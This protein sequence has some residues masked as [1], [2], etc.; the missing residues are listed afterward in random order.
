MTTQMIS[1]R[2]RK[3]KK[4]STS[5]SLCQPKEWSRS[6]PTYPIAVIPDHTG[7]TKTEQHGKFVQ[8]DRNIVHHV[9]DEVDAFKSHHHVST[10]LTLCVYMRMHV[11]F[12]F[13]YFFCM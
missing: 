9:P 2:E 11:F 5:L 7:C 3:L 13:I 12:L 1:G 6:Q 8:Y 10:L 4:R